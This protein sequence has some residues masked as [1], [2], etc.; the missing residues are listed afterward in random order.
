MEGIFKRIKNRCASVK[1]WC[2]L[3]SSIQSF[4]DIQYVRLV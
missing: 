3:I 4:T 2:R 1:D